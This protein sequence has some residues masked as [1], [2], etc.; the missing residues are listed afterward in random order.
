MFKGQVQAITSYNDSY[1]KEWQAVINEQEAVLEVVLKQAEANVQTALTSRQLALDAN[2]VAAQVMAQLGAAAL[3]A[4]HWS[5]TANW[6]L[7]SS[8]SLSSVSST[9]T[10]TNTNYNASV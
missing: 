7:S 4:I 6:S 1:I 10:N 5:N 8:S 2:K 3:N 9:S